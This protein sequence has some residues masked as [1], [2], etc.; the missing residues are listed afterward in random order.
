MN[1]DRSFFESSNLIGLPRLVFVCRHVVPVSNAHGLMA[2]SGGFSG[3]VTRIWN[4]AAPVA[5]VV[6]AGNQNA[7][8]VIVDEEVV[9]WLRFA[10]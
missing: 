10:V 8:M 2:L 1:R 5:A 4:L 9:N 6:A 7:R 3:C